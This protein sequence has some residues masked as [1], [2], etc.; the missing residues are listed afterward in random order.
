MTL[1]AVRR[2]PAVKIGQGDIAREAKWVIRECLRRNYGIAIATAGC[3]A[4]YVK[5]WLK[6]F[7]PAVFTGAGA[8]A[9][10]AQ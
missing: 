1:A 8:A 5:P 10:R 2:L 9:A 3:Q 6:R 4:G 7:D